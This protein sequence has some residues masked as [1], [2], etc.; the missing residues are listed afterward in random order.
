MMY[1]WIGSMGK[2]FRRDAKNWREK[3]ERHTRL[4]ARHKEHERT[5]A[6][7]Q[8]SRQASRHACMHACTHEVKKRGIRTRATLTPLSEEKLHMHS[9][10]QV[11]E[12]RNCLSAN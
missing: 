9:R 11:R 12:T 6:R 1:V 8:A 2:E 10:T 4:P 3:N 5:H 7:R